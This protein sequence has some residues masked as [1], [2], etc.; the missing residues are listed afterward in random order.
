MSF[1]KWLMDICISHN[2]ETGVLAESISTNERFPRD[3]YIGGERLNTQFC[4]AVLRLADILD[5]DFERTPRALFDNLAID[6]KSLPGAEVSLKEWQKHMS[7]HSV[8]VKPDEIEVF[9]DTL[10]PS[11][12]Q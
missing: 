1:E 12:I 2:S 3:I 4:A 9:A 8:N 5:L 11:I 7:L 10:H 6:S